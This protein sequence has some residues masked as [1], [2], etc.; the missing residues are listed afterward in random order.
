VIAVE[1]VLLAPHSAVPRGIL[2][3][4]D[5]YMH[6]QRALRLLTKGDSD[7]TPRPAHTMPPTASPSIGTAH[8]RHAAGRR[9]GA[10]ESAAGFD[11][12]P[13]LYLLGIVISPDSLI[14]AL[15][16]LPGACGRASAAS[17][18]CG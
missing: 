18:F 4:P 15:Q 6:L 7:Q 11:A 10:A 9:G 2:F 5:C 12:L 16:C 3:D 8:V 1:A 17:S 14:A 13:L